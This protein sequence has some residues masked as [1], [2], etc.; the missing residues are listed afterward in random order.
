MYNCSMREI[1]LTQGK[2]AIIDDEDF[3]RI[4]KY[5]W[6]AVYQHGD[7]YAIRY[8]KKLNGKQVNQFMH[9]FILNTPEKLKTDHRNHNTLD[10]RKCNIRICTDAQNSMNR[11]PCQHTSSQYKGVYWDRGRKKWRA[12]IRPNNKHLNLG[13]YNNEIDAAYAYDIAAKELFGE[14]AYLNF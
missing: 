5:K 7:W 2:Y 13:H 14:F 11:Q 10:N 4:N 6:H 1:K 9:R 3:G 12:H 8:V